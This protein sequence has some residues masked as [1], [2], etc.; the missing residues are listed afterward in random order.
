M[1][2][3]EMVKLCAD[4][5][6]LEVVPYPMVT[7]VFVRSTWVKTA[8]IIYDPLKDDK[9]AMALA[10]RYPLVFEKS[11]IEWANHVRRNEPFNV[12]HDLCARIAKGER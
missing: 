1:N 6:G 7:H 5:M 10:R 4:A 2:D 11:V 8:V 9:K 3:L 12:N